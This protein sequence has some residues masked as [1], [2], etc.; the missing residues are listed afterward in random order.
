[1]IGWLVIGDDGVGIVLASE[2][3]DT[4]IPAQIESDLTLQREETPSNFIV[5]GATKHY[6]EIV[7]LTGTRVG[8]L[9]QGLRLVPPG[10]LIGWI[11]PSSDVPWS[12]MYAHNSTTQ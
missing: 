9:C 6:G 10:R 3:F 1:V 7:L 4:S 12:V 11:A 8:V 5:P 2:S